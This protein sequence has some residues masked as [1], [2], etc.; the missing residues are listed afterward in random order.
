[1]RQRAI[2]LEKSRKPQSGVIIGSFIISREYREIVINYRS[3]SSNIFQCLTVQ[4]NR[5]TNTKENDYHQKY[6]KKGKVAG[7]LHISVYNAKKDV[8]NSRTGS[9]ESTLR[10]Q[11][12]ARALEPERSSK[13][14]F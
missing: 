3:I 13:H 10:N 14:G 7:F 1:M 11:A 5:E 2:S 12:R 8:N 6:P 9:E 4:N